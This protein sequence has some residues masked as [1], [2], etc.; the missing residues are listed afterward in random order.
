MNEY[1]LNSNLAPAD[2]ILEGFSFQTLIDNLVGRGGEKFTPEMIRAVYHEMMDIAADDSRF[3]LELNFEEIAAE[4]ERQRAEP[5]PIAEGSGRHVSEIINLAEDISEALQKSN[6]PDWGLNF[7]GTVKYSE[8]GK[9]RIRAAENS[10]AELFQ[11]D[12]TPTIISGYVRGKEGFEIIRKTIMNTDLM[13]LDVCTK[14]DIYYW[15]VA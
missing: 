14:G 1:K 4:A 10:D 8:A 5:D 13:V 2:F 15:T 7:L 9:I 3:L 6:I 11:I 12:P